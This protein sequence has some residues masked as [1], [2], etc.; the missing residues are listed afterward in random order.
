MT[1]NI[2]SS[3]RFRTAITRW[4]D[5]IQ[6]KRYRTYFD[7]GYRVLLAFIQP[8]VPKNTIVLHNR[9]I[10]CIKYNFKWSNLTLLT[11][12]YF[13]LKK[14]QVF[15]CIYYFLVLFYLVFKILIAVRC[16]LLKLRYN[17]NIQ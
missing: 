4:V 5:T 1:R 10:L 14:I 11:N 9:L 17:S 6:V 2:I 3:Q 16:C 7:V 13:Y 12:T 15:I 8:L